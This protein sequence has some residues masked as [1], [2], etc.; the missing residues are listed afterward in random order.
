MAERADRTW[1]PDGLLVDKPHPARIYDYLVGGFHNFAADRQLADAMGELYPHI[2]SGTV[3][4]RAFLRRAVGFLA[5][6]GIDQFLDIGSG[7]PTA[8]NVHEAAQAANPEARV[9]YVDNDP[10]VLSHSELML[11]EDPRA[12]LI[13][14]DLVS[15][16]AI[17]GHDKV[18]DL[19]DLSRPLAVLL[20]AVLHYVLDDEDAEDAVRR[21]KQR[22]VSGSYVVLSHPCLDEASREILD[23]VLPLYQ[24]TSDTKVR[25]LDQ[26]R[27]YFDGLELVEPGLVRA[28]VWRPEAPDD[29]LA[30]QP[31]QYLGFV[32]V[33]RKP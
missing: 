17:F 24:S 18:K 12:T 27:R 5:D 21:I 26:I 23:R 2:R 15:T 33:G 10:V 22:L 7:L 4:Q 1:V 30:D 31:E 14:E 19:L 11:S 13:C 25:S 8:G 6:Q 3:A 9:V 20:N 29:V 32:G 28:P 16:E